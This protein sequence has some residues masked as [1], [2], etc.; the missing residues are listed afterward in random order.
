MWGALSDEE[1]VCRLQLML[2]LASAIILGL[3]SRG[4]RDHILLSQF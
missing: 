4:S 3:E 1:R 2:V